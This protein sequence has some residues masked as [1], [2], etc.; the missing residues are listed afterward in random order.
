[1]QNRISIWRDRD[2]PNE[3]HMTIFL[4]DQDYKRLKEIVVKYKLPITEAYD[5]M[6]SEKSQKM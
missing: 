3:M 1:M 2:Q 5:R 4:D 6:R